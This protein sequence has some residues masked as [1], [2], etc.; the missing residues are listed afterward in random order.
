MRG[1]FEQ[2]HNFLHYRYLIT[3]FLTFEMLPFPQ[4]NSTTK[5][6]LGMLLNMYNYP[7]LLGKGS[8]FVKH[9]EQQIFGYKLYG[10]SINI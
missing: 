7:N 10:H 4:Y 5:N 3:L 2:T 6:L 8:K 9:K 1:N